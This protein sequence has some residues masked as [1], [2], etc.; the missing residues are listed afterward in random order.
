MSHD[1]YLCMS[2]ALDW[3][4]SAGFTNG[5]WSVPTWS[6]GAVRGFVVSLGMA[7]LWRAVFAKQRTAISFRAWIDGLAGRRAEARALFLQSL[8][9]MVGDVG[10]GANG[11]RNSRWPRSKTMLDNWIRIRC[12]A[13]GKLEPFPHRSH[14]KSRGCNCVTNFETVFEAPK[15]PS[16]S[17]FNF[18]ESRGF[19][20]SEHMLSFDFSA[21]GH[22]LF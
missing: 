14:C 19:T 22:L 11:S 6:R 2:S 21:L 3:Y 15:A 16:G 4:L 7:T 9:A 10:L 13:L 20:Q 17:S 5:A 8:L 12:R 18:F 1:P